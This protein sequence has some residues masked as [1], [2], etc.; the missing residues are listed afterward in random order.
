VRGRLLDALQRDTQLRSKLSEDI[1]QRLALLSQAPDCL[2]LNGLAEFQQDDLLDLLTTWLVDLG[3][4][5]PT[6]KFLKEVTQNI[7]AQ[8]LVDARAGDLEIRQHGDQLY[9]LKVLPDHEVDSIPLEGEATRLAGMTVTNESVE[10]KGLH[11][12][13]YQIRFRQGGET[14]KQRHD[15]SLKNLCQEGGL[16]AWLR[17]RLPLIYLGDEL[18]ALAAVP[19]WGFAMQIADGHEASEAESGLKI[20]LHLDDRW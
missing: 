14:L 3:V 6:G 9:A 11:R 12:G 5:L 15:R 17:S 16:P 13:D 7:L 4:P 10:G 2:D 1:G 19:A 8:R 20:A 18:V